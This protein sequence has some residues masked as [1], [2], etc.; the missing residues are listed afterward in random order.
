MLSSLPDHLHER[1]RCCSQ[2]EDRATGEF[3]LYWMATAVRADENP[4]FDVA[5]H[6]AQQ[7]K[8]PLLV[9]QG[10]SEHYQ[11]ASD[12]HHTFMLHGA[13]D[14]QQQLQSCGISY[15]F[16]LA[17]WQDRAPHLV[18]L[19][20]QAALVV[21]ED[22]PVGPPQHFR[23]RLANRTQTPIWL[24]DTACVVPMQLVGQ[25]HTRAFKFRKAT[26]KLYR[27][28]T[29]CDWPQCDF[30]VQAFDLAK[31]PFRPIDL[32]QA[33]IGELVSGCEIDHAV[34]PVPDTPG[35]S[36]AGY[37]R[38]N[39]FK[40]NRLWRYAKT[41][42]DPL[43]TG[44]SRMSAYLHYGM[45]SPFRIAREAA[46]HDDSGAEKYLDELLIW[47][48]LAYGFCFYRQDYNQWS[49]LP[50]W[51]QT[52]LAAHGSDQRE[53]TFTWEQLARA[54]TGDSLWDA[55]QL[56]LLRQGELHNNV[57][58]TW[59]KAILNWT[60]SPQQALQTIIDLN[61][62]Y[63]LDGRDPASYGGILWCL[64]QFD[65]PFKPEKRV[66]GTVRPRPTDTHAR[67]LDVDRYRTQ[68]SRPRYSGPLRVAVIG[69]GISG[70]FA[71]R[72]M[73]DHGIDVTVF[74]KSRGLGGRMATR[75]TDHGAFDHGAQYFTA[76]DH[77]F[78]RYVNSWKEMGLVQCWPN[79]GKHPPIV[80]LEN[81]TLKSESNSVD[82]FVAT[83]G[84]NSI[85][86]HL[87]DGIQ[88][89]TKT[90][91]DRIRRSGAQ[92]KLFDQ[93]DS[94]LGPFDRLILSL[95]SGQAAELLNSEFPDL[96]SK[97]SQV[98]MNPCWATMATLPAPVT[99]RWSGAFLHDSFLSWTSRNNTK[100]GR[101]NEPECIVIHATP[102]WTLQHWE[103]D[104]DQVAAWML[105]EYWNATGCQPQS[106][107]HLQ[108]H[109]WK[110]ALPVETR[111]RRPL[112]DNQSV[113]TVCG[114]WT[115]GGRIEGAFLS[116][117][118]AAG[119][120]LGSLV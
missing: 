49:A 19:A 65:R 7:L 58:M 55:A 69:A 98:N 43:A 115:A 22:M 47:R 56:S 81:G 15:A 116:G 113:V 104:A 97:I 71:A 99:N 36:R 83:P 11:F 108:A 86:R 109:R 103:D 51:A 77:R 3:V 9:Y 16:H 91:V 95:P 1:T 50:D 87:A 107:L 68:T 90:R 23:Q 92:I 89:Q 32:Q 101:S 45:V 52:T 114:D 30:P 75:R 66:L 73:G 64:G 33:S 42:N 106:P 25:A 48:E 46:H 80:V 78:Q 40:T 14:V 26:A 85:C 12:R 111:N 35:G 41:R 105:A 67:R 61:H 17:T 21:T 94:E 60:H 24:V 54:Q 39:E 96:A 110:Y 2:N 82:R 62:R 6:A 70:L 4:A 29:Q 93:D 57:R 34:G 79:V 102:D 8:L 119:R 44:S 20:Q 118:S 117:M 27:E 59:G 38:W 28:R 31:L 37:A 84:M 63:A 13:R 10:L 100:P 74:E 72:T 18:N 88:V 76:R 5:R 112:A 53:S 120:I